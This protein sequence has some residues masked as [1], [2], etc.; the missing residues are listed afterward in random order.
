MKMTI[1]TMTAEQNDSN[2]KKTT[3]GK[4][5]KYFK[6]VSC[7]CD[8]WSGRYFIMNVVCPAESKMNRSSQQHCW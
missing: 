8:Q 3:P 1:G 6:Y 2:H 5:Q 4:V 7:E